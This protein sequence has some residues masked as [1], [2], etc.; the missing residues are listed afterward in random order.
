M[1]PKKTSAA[2]IAAAIKSLAI[3]SGKHSLAARIRPAFEHKVATDIA[4]RIGGYFTEADLVKALE[5]YATQDPRLFLTAREIEGELRKS[6]RESNEP[7]SVSAS[8]TLQEKLALLTAEHRLYYANT[9][10]FPEGAIKQEDGEDS[11]T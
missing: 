9:G 11:P 2:L 10:R 1:T 5:Q 7:K 4:L 8:A 3:T 6:F